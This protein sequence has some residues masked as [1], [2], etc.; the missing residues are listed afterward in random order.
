MTSAKH[1]TQSTLT[2]PE[3]QQKQRERERLLAQLIYEMDASGKPLYYKGYRE[4][5]KGIVEPEAIMGASSLQSF[6]VDLFVTF[7]KLHPDRKRFKHF[8]NEFGVQI[9]R[10]KWRACDIAIYHRE[11]LKGFVYSNKYMNLPPDYVIEIDTKADLDK[12]KN[13]QAYFIEKTRQ[14]HEFGVKKVIWIFTENAQVIWESNAGEPITIH[15]SW[16]VDLSLTDEV[17]FN[18]ARLIEAEENES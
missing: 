7:L 10:K 17:T 16:D 5:L 15:Q 12:Y 11:R 2:A 8:Y 6:L 14:L 13:Q 3:R 4:V 9:T 1:T 18:L